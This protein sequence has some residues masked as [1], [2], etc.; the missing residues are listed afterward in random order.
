LTFSVQAFDI[1]PKQLEQQCSSHNLVVSLPF[2]FSGTAIS[3]AT[4]FNSNAQTA[5]SP[6]SSKHSVHEV[7]EKRLTF[8]IEALQQRL[9]R[10]RR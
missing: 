9:L 5:M 8:V 2:G 10:Q 3:H 7:A 4:V 6:P 1:V